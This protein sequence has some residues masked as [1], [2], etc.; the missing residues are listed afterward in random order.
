MREYLPKVKADL[1]YF[2]PPYVTEFSA[3][4]YSANY[5]VVDA[6]MVKGEGRAPN[7]ASVTRMVKTQED[8][9]KMNVGAFF[10]E[11]FAAA[12]HIPEWI[13]SY[14]DHS[15]PTE[16]EM[17]VLFKASGR[18]V[19]LKTKDSSYGGLEGKGREEAPAKAR[20]YLLWG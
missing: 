8:L 2:D 1:A 16:E 9:T 13:L 3:A 17:K 11:V 19:E 4:N 14:R 12:E 18:D 7:E 6:V 20:E 5:H 10:Q 15:H